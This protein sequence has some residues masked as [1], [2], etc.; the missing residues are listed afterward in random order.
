MP[1]MPKSSAWGR[2]RRFR[3]RGK[4]GEVTHD[5]VMQAA[6]RVDPELRR[7]D[8]L[9]EPGDKRKAWE[10]LKLARRVFNETYGGGHGA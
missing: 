2:I 5:D 9:R 6:V 1:M 10:D 3:R 8:L 4:A 7:A